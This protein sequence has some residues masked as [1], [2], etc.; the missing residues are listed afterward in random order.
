MEWTLITILLA[1]AALLR[2]GPSLRTRALGPERDRHADAAGLSRRIGEMRVGALNDTIDDY[3]TYL[4]RRERLLNVAEE[5]LDDIRDEIEGARER[6]ALYLR[7]ARRRGP[8]RSRRPRF[9]RAA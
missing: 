4:R 2:I 6:L 9:L 3:V 1:L 8:Q 7:E 5:S